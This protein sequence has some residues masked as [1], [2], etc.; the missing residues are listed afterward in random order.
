MTH[1]EQRIKDMLFLIAEDKNLK[2]EINQRIDMSSEKAY[3]DKRDGHVFLS[4]AEPFT[5]EHL[6]QWEE[7]ISLAITLLDNIRKDEQYAESNPNFFKATVA[8][9]QNLKKYK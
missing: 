3:V 6:T 2:L 5:E 8:K 1:Q 7:A 4:L 9:I